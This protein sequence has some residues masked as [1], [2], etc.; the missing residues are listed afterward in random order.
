M[1]KRKVIP[2]AVMLFAGV[3][4]A[5]AMASG[6]VNPKVVTA[7]FARG[8]QCWN[9]HGDATEVRANFRRGQTVYASS[10]GE[11]SISHGDWVSTTVE[12]RDLD[13]V[14]PNGA[15]V[16]PNHDHGFIAPLTGTYSFGF[17][18]CSY[19]HGVGMFI[20]CAH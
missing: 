2:I 16:E 7:H 1:A 18:P 20:L 10:A 13:I 15:P 4:H 8:A 14:G 6:C 19:W 5:P 17:G 9:Y 12:Q 3:T 11:D